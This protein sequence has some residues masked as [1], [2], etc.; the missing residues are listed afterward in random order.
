MEPESHLSALKI[1]SCD[2]YW[3][4]IIDILVQQEG[5]GRKKGVP[6]PKQFQNGEAYW[7]SWCEVSPPL[8]MAL[9]QNHF[10]FLLK[11]SIYFPLNGFVSLSPAH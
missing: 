9:S 6:G 3:V 1:Q 10:P 11:D 7:L 8:L 2:E 5:N 4:P